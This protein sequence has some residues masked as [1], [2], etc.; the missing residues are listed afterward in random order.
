MTFKE[1]LLKG[2]YIINIEAHED[3]RGFFARSFCKQTFKAQGIDFDV[4]QSNLSFNKTRGI[5]RGLHYQSPPDEEAKLV[6]CMRGAIYDVIVDIR[7][8]S[9]TFKK[10]AAFELSQKNRQMLFIPEGFAHGFQTLEDETDV[11]YLM[12]KPYRPD[13]ARG[14]PWN[15]AAFGIHWPIHPERL[16][17]KDRSY[18]S[19][20]L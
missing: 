11:F 16:S 4:A 7:P 1:S 15:D 12:S 13:S 2:A 6:H 10:W 9:P 18:A 14:L 5:L 20:K 19:F 17:E 8:E 3:S